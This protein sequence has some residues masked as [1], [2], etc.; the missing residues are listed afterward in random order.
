[1]A[2]TSPR[3]LMKF[4]RAFTS[5][6]T[7]GVLV[8]GGLTYAAT[9]APTP[10]AA[11]PCIPGS[12]PTCVPGPGPGPTTDVPTGPATTAPQAP[13][14]TPPGAQQPT[15]SPSDPTPN[16]G[17][18][19]M[20]VQTPNQ[21]ATTNPN[22]IFGPTPS[23]TPQPPQDAPTT[24][25]PTSPTQSAPTSNATSPSQTQSADDS[26]CQLQT[27][28][29]SAVR[30][31]TVSYSSS[32]PSIGGASVG[33][34]AAF[35]N[36]LG[37]TQIRPAKPGESPSVEI[38]TF[39]DPSI[40]WRAQYTAPDGD[41]SA[42]IEV[43]L[44]HYNGLDPRLQQTLLTHEMGHAL[45]LADSKDPRSVMSGLAYPSSPS[46][47]DGIELGRLDPSG[48]ACGQTA[49]QKQ[50][51]PDCVGPKGADGSCQWADC[52]VV[53]RAHGAGEGGACN[54]GNWDEPGRIWDMVEYAM[55]AADV[56]SLV[57]PATAAGKFAVKFAVKKYLEKRAKDKIAQEAAQK[58]ADELAKQMLK[59]MDDAVEAAK[60]CANSFPL[61]IPV[62]MA[63]GAQRP[64]GEVQVG[65]RVA[66]Q[67]DGAKTAGS[68]VEVIQS[69]REQ[70]VVALSLS[71]GRTL[72]TT[73]GH[74]FW[75]VTVR[76]FVPAR[77]LRPGSLL[78]DSFGRQLSVESI[79]VSV[80][81]VPVKNLQVT[82]GATFF[83]GASAVLVHNC[84]KR[85]SEN[86]RL[87]NK[88]VDDL[89][90]WLGAEKTSQLSAGNYPIYKLGKQYITY[91]RSGHKG[92]AA[93]WK[94]AS[95]PQYLQT[96]SNT[97]RTGTYNFDLSERLGK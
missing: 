34:A 41:S 15:E 73:A 79:G 60:G 8:A 75:D 22:G 25:Q 94:V 10:A 39:N 18:N 51:W 88:Q 32:A 9:E 17:G 97:N 69:S 89:A 30:D 14:T 54:L 20:N 71:D 23:A 77:Q 52:P 49:A 78:V 4:S 85:G 3:R 96:T 55:I 91:D 45:G 13:T 72:E 31:G 5:I 46:A 62:L 35:W 82:P 93:I 76:D 47:A 42:T 40:S 83:A 92:S 12:A 80:R 67:A 68:V 57:N 11:E 16:Q 2:H 95:K 26:Q 86:I 19:G 43:N 74:P 87:T 38:T 24:G 36:G 33:D 59:D 58:E 37:R 7:A 27:V 64:I 28:N 56:V 48:A 53:G 61:S 63:N 90:R 21:P 44:A 65:D 81:T 66:A 50:H 6:L 70:F 1:M 29:T 84:S